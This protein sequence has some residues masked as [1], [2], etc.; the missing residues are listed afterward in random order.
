MTPTGTETEVKISVPEHAAVLSRAEQLGFT[1]AVPRIFESNTIYD[2]AGQELRK[3]AMLLRLRQAGGRFVITWK[4]KMEPGSHKIRPELET[5][6]GSLETMQQILGHLAYNPVFRYEK[7]RTELKQV[8]APDSGVLT[9][10]E[11]PIGN[12]LELEGRGDWIDR[13]AQELGFQQKNYILKSYGQLYLD[14][15][16]RHGLEPT[17]M[18]FASHNQ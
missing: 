4:G 12:F 3:N 16:Q 6:L 15:C 14:Y 9:L 2:T 10:D 13:T 1:I 8:E 17:H 7:F 18:T 11:T 5:T